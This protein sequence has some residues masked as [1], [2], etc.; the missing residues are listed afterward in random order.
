M[1]VELWSQGIG[2]G[3]HAEINYAD[4]TGHCVWPMVVHVG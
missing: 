2:S 4:G 3:S 1:A